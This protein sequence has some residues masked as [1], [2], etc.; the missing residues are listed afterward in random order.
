[1]IEIG[2]G[3]STLVT[4]GAARRNAAEGH[5]AAFSS[6]DPHP[7]AFLAD[8][9]EGLDALH[10]VGAADVPLAA[11]DELEVGDVLFIDSTHTVKI[12]GDVNHLILDVL[13]RLAPGV[14]VHFHDIFLPHEYPRRWI[15]EEGWY[16]AEQYLLQAYLAFNDDYETMLPIAAL[17]R[18]HRDRLGALFPEIDSFRGFAAYWI[19][20]TGAGILGD[21][22]ASAAPRATATPARPGRG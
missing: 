19:Q 6:F 4:A 17:A 14:L 18:A 10:A 11:F 13:P 22:P 16:W 3:W 9:V 15:V 5:P 8:G 21:P 1:M 2:A 7:A 20:R 12:D